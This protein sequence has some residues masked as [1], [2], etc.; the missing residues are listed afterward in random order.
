MIDF[1]PLAGV[2]WLT[3]NV[4]EILIARYTLKLQIPI[5]QVLN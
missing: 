2:F 4:S 3:N 5:N 1:Q